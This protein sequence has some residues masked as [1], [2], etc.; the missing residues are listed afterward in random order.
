MKL[1]LAEEDVSTITKMLNQAEQ[2]YKFR[3]HQLAIE[4][5]KVALEVDWNRVNSTRVEKG[6]PKITNEANRNH[7]FKVKFEQEDLELLQLELRYH[8][9]QRI[10]EE[11]SSWF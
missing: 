5:S 3:R 6:L 2:E 11:M 1:E 4:K 9:L 7:Y 8:A 10:C